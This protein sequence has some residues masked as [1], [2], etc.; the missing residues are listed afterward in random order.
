MGSLRDFIDS[1]RLEEYRDFANRYDEGAPH[2]GIS[3]EEAIH[4]YRE[5]APNLSE[6]DYQLSARD[7][8]ARMS[9]E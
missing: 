7:T 2:E 4:R 9:S 8:F 1:D 5:V 6:E 3:D